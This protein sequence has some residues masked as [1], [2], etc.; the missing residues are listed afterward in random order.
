LKSD[1]LRAIIEFLRQKVRLRDGG[2]D[3][4]VCI[5]FGT[6]TRDEMIESGLD[7]AGCTA[8]L[9]APWWEEMVTDII[10]TPEMCD[11]DDSP[12]QILEFAR[13]VVSEYVR[14]RV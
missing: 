6:P 5:E 7:A 8:I 10:E 11:T 13:D 4:G 3:G 12:E 1:E 9:E 14:K 2:S